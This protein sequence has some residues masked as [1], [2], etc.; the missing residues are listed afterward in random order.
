M[1]A[2]P[3]AIYANGHG[4]SQTFLSKIEIILVG[5]I[6]TNLQTYNFNNFLSAKIDILIKQTLEN[7]EGEI[8][9][10]G[11]HVLFS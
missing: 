8:K 9:K 3:T 7:T 11:L 5:K 4:L 10:I 1:F 6:L 2:L